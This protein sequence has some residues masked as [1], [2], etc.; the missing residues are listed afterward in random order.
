VAD[1]RAARYLYPAARVV[2]DAGADQVRVVSL[3]GKGNILEVVMNQKCAAGLGL[4]IK[5]MART[6]G[7]TI[8]EMSK[9]P[10]EAP[11][12]ALVNDGC[13]VFGELDAIAMIHNNTP[14]ADI[15]RAV[16]EAVATRINSI[17]NDKIK[18]EKSATVLMGGISRNAGVIGALK[19]RSGIN[20]LIP[21]NAQF[22]GA[23]GAALIAAG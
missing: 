21:E 3:D 4:F 14:K 5:A 17:L 9:L 12:P 16:D 1:A 13:C 2:L 23:L 8:E 11:P 6:L 10:A 7:L 15:V 22:G 19:R 20:F 18:P